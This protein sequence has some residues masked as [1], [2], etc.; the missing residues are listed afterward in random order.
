MTG[1]HGRIAVYEV[2]PMH[3]KLRALILDGASSAELKKTAIDSGMK[4]LRQSAL[5]KVREG[6]TTL[7]EVA[8]VTMPN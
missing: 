5:T 4:T 8:R 6:M 2:M 3:K 7:S 1:F